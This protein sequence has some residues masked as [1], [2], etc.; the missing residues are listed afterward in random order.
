MDPTLRTRTI[1]RLK[2]VTPTLSPRLKTVAKYI[3]DNPAEFGLDSIRETARK[4]GVST[5]TL[6]RMAH[7]MGFAGYDDMREPFRHALVSSTEDVDGREWVDA[8]RDSGPAGVAHASATLNS[9]AVVQRSLQRQSTE[10]LE[11][12]AD[13][14]LQARTVYVTAMRAS[15]GLAFHFHY[16]AKMALK[17]IQLAPSHVGSAIDELSDAGPGDVVLAVTFTPYSRET[18]E[19]AMFAK[20]RGATVVFVT[21]SEVV[22]PHFKPDISLLVS[23]NSTH[24]F[25]CNSGAMAVLEI[26]LAMIFQG[27]DQ[28]TET[29]IRKYEDLR[30][31]HNAYWVAQKKH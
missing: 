23:T 10:K 24:H 30:T 8:L 7:Q 1:S 14:L 4:S 22:A 20:S 25:A 18:I 11:R 2:E 9:L 17:S 29:R 5:F 26:L 27:G 15:Y 28:T 19:A 6:V 13:L 3:L 16:I 31:A 21:D 12:V